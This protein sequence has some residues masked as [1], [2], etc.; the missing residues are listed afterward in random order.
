MIR[1]MRAELILALMLVLVSP[2]WAAHE[3]V[4]LGPYNVSFDMNTTMQYQ[5][6]TEPPTT[7]VTSS[8]FK[9]VRYNMSIETADYFASVI[10]TGYEKPMLAS[11]NANKEIVEAALMATGCERPEL[12][13]PLMDG[14][15]GV[16]GRCKLEGGNVLVISSYSP[17][18]AVRENGEYSGQTDCRVMSI[19]PWEITRDMLYTM[20]VEV[21]AP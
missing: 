13:Q 21:P 8:G 4:M 5:I 6:F 14:Q 3:T 2:G 16:L 19:F 1:V 12:F 9:F 7:G 15:P 11:I 18:G 17:D 10:L 20:H